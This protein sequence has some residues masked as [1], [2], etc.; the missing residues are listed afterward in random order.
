MDGKTEFYPVSI[1]PNET[2]L[3]DADSAQRTAF[4]APYSIR[5]LQKDESL[6]KYTV[7]Y[8]TPNSGLVM[9]YN[10]CV[11]HWKE[12]FGYELL[13][14]EREFFSEMRN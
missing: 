2:F 7:D 8:L 11:D 1:W 14:K 4:S 5:S 10:K 13:E 12:N 3:V 9:Q 6:K